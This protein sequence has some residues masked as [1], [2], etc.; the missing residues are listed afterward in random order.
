M[1]HPD[2]CSSIVP[3]HPVADGLHQRNLEGC[4]APEQMDADS[5]DVATPAAGP[6]GLSRRECAWPRSGVVV[7]RWE[8]TGTLGL[9]WRRWTV[10]RATSC[11]SA[12]THSP[13]LPWLLT[14]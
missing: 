2:S 6:E 3:A 8:A 14:P 7:A 10:S 4:R 12:P 13:S 5:E 9:L 11:C 1:A